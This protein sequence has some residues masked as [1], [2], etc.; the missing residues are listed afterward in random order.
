MHYHFKGQ[1][2]VNSQTKRKENEYKW[3]RAGIIFAVCLN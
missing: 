2:L 1:Q 3:D